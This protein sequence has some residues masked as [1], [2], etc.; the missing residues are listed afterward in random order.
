MYEEVSEGKKKRSWISNKNRFV[1]DAKAEVD[2]EAEARAD[3]EA[4]TEVEA[5][6]HVQVLFGANQKRSKVEGTD[7]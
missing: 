3:A 4:K 6:A 7:R 5:E 1:A 2:A